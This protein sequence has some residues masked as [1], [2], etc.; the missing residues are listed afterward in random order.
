MEICGL[1][2]THFFLDS[3][4]T[5]E[6]DVTKM[7]HFTENVPKWVKTNKL[8]L[9]EESLPVGLLNSVDKVVKDP[10]SKLIF[11]IL[12]GCVILLLIALV[13]HRVYKLYKDRLIQ[14]QIKVFIDVF[15]RRHNRN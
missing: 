7:D 9:D 13:S 2:V 11:M 3:T 5:R 14:I 12:M 15:H 4:S 10:V 8:L 6:Y 1:L